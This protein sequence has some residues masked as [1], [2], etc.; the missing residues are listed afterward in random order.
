MHS[1]S[2]RRKLASAALLGFRPLGGKI[3]TK[4]SIF[5]DGRVMECWNNGVL[6]APSRSS[7][8]ATTPLLHHATTPSR[9]SLSSMAPARPRTENTTSPPAIDLLEKDWSTERGDAIMDQL[10]KGGRANARSLAF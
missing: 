7:H 5:Q 8:H 3:D 4:L 1:R 9:H 6:G 2:V 10:K